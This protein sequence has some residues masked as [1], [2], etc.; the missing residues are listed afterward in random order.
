MI[1]GVEGATQVWKRSPRCQRK[2]R[3][4][5]QWIQP[6]YP[7]SR[8]VTGPK[9]S[10]HIDDRG[11]GPF[12]GGTMLRCER[13]RAGEENETQSLKAALVN[14]LDDSRLA[15]NLGERA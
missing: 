15:A 1:A 7:E 5:E 6:R 3:R 13:R 4:R 2:R 8:T 9:T 10:G 12:S 14:S 11:T